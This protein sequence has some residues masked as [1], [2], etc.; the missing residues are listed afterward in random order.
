[1]ITD[2]EIWVQHVTPETKL[3]SIRIYRYRPPHKVQQSVKKVIAVVKCK[4]CLYRMSRQLMQSDIRKHRIN[5]RKLFVEK[6]RPGRLCKAGHLA[7][8]NNV[9]PQS[10]WQK[11][12]YIWLLRFFLNLIQ[13]IGPSNDIHWGNGHLRYYCCR[14]ANM[15]HVAWCYL[16]RVENAFIHR[17]Q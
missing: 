10:T 8:H 14:C 12:E 16:H 9:A 3:D 7:S 2:D 5:W 1:M 15:A 11:S 4:C 6:K 17:W 13:G